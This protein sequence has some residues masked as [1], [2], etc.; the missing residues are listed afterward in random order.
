MT[1]DRVRELWRHR[2]SGETYLVELEDGRVLS[3][4]GPLAE[5]ELTREAL[6]LR[7]AAQGRMPAFTP[8]AA[9]PRPKR[10]VRPA[11]ARN[12]MRAVRCWCEELVVSDDDEALGRELAAHVREA[13]PGE[14]RGEDEIRERVAAEAEDAPDRPPWA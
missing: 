13:H 6:T 8:E 5:D 1:G 14:P 10:R 2:D 12:L 9:E 4:D 3:G 11:A 7:R